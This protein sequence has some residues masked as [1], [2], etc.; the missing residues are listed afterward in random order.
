MNK[1]QLYLLKTFS[2]TNTNKQKNVGNYAAARKAAKRFLFSYTFL[3]C[4]ILIPLIIGL[5]R[6]DLER[7]RDFE[8]IIALA[9]FCLFLVFI[10]GIPIYALILQLRDINNAEVFQKKN[11]ESESPENLRAEIRRVLSNKCSI[12]PIPEGINADVLTELYLKEKTVGEKDGFIPVILQLDCNLIENI[13][14]NI[15][16]K[17]EEVS[18]IKE[19]IHEII[20]DLKES[21]DA[22]SGEWEEYIG[23]EEDSKEYTINGFNEINTENGKFVMIHIPS[24]N[25]S[26]VFSF[27]PMGDWNA[28]PTPSQ[29]QAYTKYWNEL[30][31]AVPCFISSDIIMYHVPEPVGKERGFNLAMEQTSYCEDIVS[32]GVG[33]IWNLAKSIENSNFWYFWWD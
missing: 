22:E 7:D 32:Q 12:T 33:T 24:L 3:I 11:I 14:E 15:N 17:Y 4:L 27:V 19:F 30:Y 21:Y 29:H 26:D 6:K 18:D 28:C 13:E 31:K 5:T 1:F 23:N 2:S 9:F 25:P 16:N 20:A 8:Q 10:F